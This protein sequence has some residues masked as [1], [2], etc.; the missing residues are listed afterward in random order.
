MVLSGTAL[1]PLGN[2]HKKSSMGKACLELSRKAQRAHQKV[3]MGQPVP[4]PSYSARRYGVLVTVSQL[5][6]V[7]A[8]LPPLQVSLPAPPSSTSAPLLPFRMSSP[9]SPKS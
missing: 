9:F 2:P 1:R 7:S 6:P 3:G 8:P 4:I 5:T